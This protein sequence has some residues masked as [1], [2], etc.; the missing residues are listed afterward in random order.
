MFPV[1]RTGL[2]PAFPAGRRLESAPLR[3]GDRAR[4]D[5]RCARHGEHRRRGG[6]CRR[7]SRLLALLLLTALVWWR[8]LNR[9]DSH[10]AA[11]GRRPARRSRRRRRLPA[12]ASRSSV[13]G[14]ATRRT[15]ERASPARARTTLVTD[16]FN[17]PE[18]AAN[19]T[20][21]GTRSPAV[22][23]IRYGPNGKPGGDPAALLLPGRDAGAHARRRRQSV[24][25]SLGDQVHAASPRSA[26][27]APGCRQRSCSVGATHAC[28]RR[29][30]ADPRHPAA[31]VSLLERPVGAE[32][33]EQGEQRRRQARPGGRAAAA[34][35]G[36]PPAQAAD[37]RS[38]PRSR[39]APPAA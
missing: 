32:R 33:L 29:R 28:S 2:P 27:T 10:A 19:D 4:T 5:R 8:V 20:A 16:G 35:D 30:T 26:V 17:V 7:S 15:R 11:H 39:S 13:D 25:V 18:P 1:K 37:A 24:T 9:G 38:R 14:A 23:E 31:D 6:R 12:P 21:E 22:A 34:A 36:G 3:F